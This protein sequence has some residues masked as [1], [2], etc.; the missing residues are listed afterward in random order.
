MPDMPAAA[1]LLLYPALWQRSLQECPHDWRA[2]FR[3]L[4]LLARKVCRDDRDVVSALSEAERLLLQSLD[5]IDVEDFIRTLEIDFA[6]EANPMARIHPDTL[7]VDVETAPVVNG[8]KVL[9]A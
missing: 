8:Y 2:Q 4:C 3:V 6:D 1:A 5:A 9:D 7:M